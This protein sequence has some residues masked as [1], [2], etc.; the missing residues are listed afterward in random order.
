VILAAAL[1]G[2]AVA[3]L[4]LPTSVAPRLAALVPRSEERDAAG[5]GRALRRPVL[6]VL[7]LFAW[8]LLGSG[9]VGLGVG[10]GL[11]L[12]LPELLERL[13]AR[14]EQDDH[15]LTRQLPL[16]LDLVGACLTG[17]SPLG[18]ALASVAAGLDG[19]AAVRLRRVAAALAVGTPTE[20]AFG[21]LGDAGAAGTAARALRRAAESGT[22][23]AA[24]VSTVAEEARR[25]ATAAARKRVRQA[26]IKAAAPITVCFLPAFLVL[27]TVP[28]VVAVTGPLL[29]AF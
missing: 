6:V 1:M 13:D 28:T 19:P 20:E 29:K 12:G 18:Q 21:E 5:P 17:G 10:A 15:E 11:A 8:W 7:G 27:G 26:G 25:S 23:V 9:L 22:P 4:A 2:S 3:V 16:A 14:A 24:A